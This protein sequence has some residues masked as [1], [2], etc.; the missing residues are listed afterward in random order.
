MKVPGQLPKRFPI[1]S[2]VEFQKGSYLV[3]S[4]SDSVHWFG[5]KQQ[6]GVNE[7]LRVILGEARGKH[8]GF[9]LFYES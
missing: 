5:P 6:C 2:R 7:G 4:P 1:G 8:Q 9:P 3:P